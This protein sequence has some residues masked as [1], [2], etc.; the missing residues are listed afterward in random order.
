MDGQGHYNPID[1]T[2]NRDLPDQRGNINSI[3][4]DYEDDVH[5]VKNKRKRRFCSMPCIVTVCVIV[6]VLG[7]AAF[8]TV[9]VLKWGIPT[10]K[11]E[12]QCDNSGTPCRMIVVESIPENLTFPNGSVEHMSTYDGLMELLSLAET[13]IDIASFYWTL[14]GSDNEH[15]PSDWQ[16]ESIFNTLMSIGKSGVKVRIVQNQPN[17]Q[18]PD[19]DSYDLA[20]AGAAEVLCINF[21]KLLGSG[22]L[23]SKFWVVDN[24]HFYIGSANLDWRSLTQIKELGVVALNCSCLTQ[25]LVKVF[26]MYWTVA[27]GHSTL[28]SK[29]PSN[30]QTS[31][32]FKNPLKI[33]INGTMAE[34]AFG[35][36]PPQFQA[37]NWSSDLDLILN[38]INLAQKQ[39]NI[40]VMDYSPTTLYMGDHNRYWPNID[41][42][43][44]HAVFD[45]GVEVRL[46]ASWWNHSKVDMKKFL[47]SLSAINST[48]NYNHLGKAEVRLFV[49]PSYNKR[50]QNIPYARVNHNK[51]MVTDNAAFIGTSNWSGD[52]FITTAGVGLLVNQT[53]HDATSIRSQLQAVFDRDWNSPYAQLLD[54]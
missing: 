49:V 14:T 5:L 15:Y 22:I 25:E 28:P 12:P 4:S 54:V 39:I 34:T 17:S 29:W 44:R 32:N 10:K 37:H 47:R 46:M 16:G 18:F 8:T 13:S 36:S 21:G 45:R 38:M 33:P 27:K 30:V 2:D 40:A 53:D 3:A 11:S 20:K 7:T 41:D 1:T 19:H 43:L 51:Y 6:I 9:Y 23:H 26:S 24:A 48:G 31:T 50:Q 35:I 52:Y 42:A